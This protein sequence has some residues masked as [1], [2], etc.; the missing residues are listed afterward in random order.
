M[1]APAL[2][3]AAELVATESAAFVDALR[4]VGG[5]LASAPVPGC[6]DWTARDLAVHLA[7]VQRFWAAA[8]RAGG[9]R[10]DLPEDSWDPGPGV[11]DAD[12]LA[13]CGD[14]TA[15]LVGALRDRSA[16][17]PCYVWWGEPATADAVARH[18]VQEAAVHR[19][20]AER[21]AGRQPAPLAGPVADD[22]VAEFFATSGSG[23]RGAA[24]RFVHR[25]AAVE[26]VAGT[27]DP[28]ATVEAPG[29]DLVLLLYGRAAIDD[30]T[31]TGDRGAVESL[32]Q[33]LDTN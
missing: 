6:P 10:P 25:D 32:L 15:E 20:D 17:D 8:V 24:V 19:W 28:V 4:E 2:G 33:G 5:S 30:V 22:G 7:G 23:Y 29:G 18:Q 3:A 26:D 13:W 31:V 27:G 14:A 16:G 12:L 1:T 21:A 11:S 9:D